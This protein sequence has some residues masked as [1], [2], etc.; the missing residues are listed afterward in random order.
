[1]EVMVLARLGVGVP[2]WQALRFANGYLAPVLW[3]TPCRRV[4]FYFVIR[5]SKCSDN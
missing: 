4:S 1:M 3:Y 5:W 2:E